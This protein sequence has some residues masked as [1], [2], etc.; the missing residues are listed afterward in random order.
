MRRS[1]PLYRVTFFRDNTAAAPP[2]ITAAHGQPPGDLGIVISGDFPDPIIITFPAAPEDELGDAKALSL[3]NAVFTRREVVGEQSAVSCSPHE[4]NI[5]IF[6]AGSE[7]SGTVTVY[8]QWGTPPTTQRYGGDLA[9][10]NTKTELIPYA[11]IWYSEIGATLGSAYGKSTTGLLHSKKIA[12]ARAVSAVTRADEC[13]R[14]NAIPALATFALETWANC[15]QTPFY[16][17]EESWRTRARCAALFSINRDGST[18][19]LERAIFYLIGD[20][21]VQLRVFDIDDAPWA[22]PL[23]YDIGGGVWASSRCEI[24]IDV[25]RPLDLNDVYYLDLIRSQL[26][27]LADRVVPSFVSFDWT[28]TEGAGFRIGISRIGFEGILS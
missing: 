1:A 17:G 12:W 26:M 15:L 8:G 2:T 16:G 10:E 27:G 11:W 21:Y 4:L 20:N 19:S 18:L 7:I 14:N 6:D 28:M 22:W 5:P 3:T 25:K 9:K 24:L 23:S 13:V